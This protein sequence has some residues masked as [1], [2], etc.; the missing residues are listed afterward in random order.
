MALVASVVLEAAEPAAVDVFADAAFGLKCRICARGADEP[1]AGFRGFSLSLV[2]SQ[3][4]TVN[5]LV[6]AALD[7]GATTLKPVKKGFWGYGGVVQAP[8]GTI[9][10]IATSSK[11]ETGPST[12]QV[13]DVVLLLGVT[14]VKASK[15]FYIEHGLTVAKSFAGK[16]VEF[17]S[18][19]SGV[20]LALLQRDALAKD[21]GVLPDGTGSRGI[22]ICSDA[23]TF[24]DPD[25]FS[26]ETAA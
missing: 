3:P 18:A 10:K 17:E 13:D 26:W 11:K 23:G 20:T 8:D 14:D 9:W 7:H 16:Y 12:R 24:T 5:N 4:S 6:A 25:G 22:V 15:M 21:V 19:P 2:V 1:S